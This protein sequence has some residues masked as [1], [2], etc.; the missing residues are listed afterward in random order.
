MVLHRLVAADP[1]AWTGDVPEVL[2]AL[3]A[4]EFGAFYLAA[5]A[6]HADCP[7][8]FPGGAL[9]GAVTAALGLVRTLGRPAAGATGCSSPARPWPTCSPPPG[10]RTPP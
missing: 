3:K 5:A 9:A 6:G 10:A 2:N 7:D 1:A 4:P 8:A